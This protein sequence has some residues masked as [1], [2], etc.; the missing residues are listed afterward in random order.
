MESA[1]LTPAQQRQ[2]EVFQLKGLRK[3]LKIKTTF[4]QRANTNSQVFNKANACIRDITPANRT[5]K[6]VVPFIRSYQNSRMKR[7]ARITKLPH[8]HPVRESTLRVD[9][10][11]PWD[12]PNKRVGRPK[13]KWVTETAKDIWTNIKNSLPAH[14][15]YLPFDINNQEIQ[16]ALKVA[17]SSDAHKP[18][19]LFT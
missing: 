19:Y 14:I 2:L 9:G 7:L 11:T 18:T 6:Q 3:I 5:P 8:T 13:Y 1:Q 16:N 10:I 4:I 15:R 17:L 12:P